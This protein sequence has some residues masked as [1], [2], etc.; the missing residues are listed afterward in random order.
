MTQ[1]NQ[2]FQNLNFVYGCILSSTGTD[3]RTAHILDSENQYV[4]ERQLCH[5]V[6]AKMAECHTFYIIIVCYDM[7]FITRRKRTIYSA[8]APM[9]TPRNHA[10][11]CTMAIFALMQ[12]RG[13]L[14][15]GLPVKVDKK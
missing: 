12:T 4:H 6:A 2:R 5:N 8:Q 3:F 15:G 10:V 11:W 14:K 1:N 9:A 7:T 13:F